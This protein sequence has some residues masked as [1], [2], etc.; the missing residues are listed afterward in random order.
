[1]LNLIKK[2]WSKSKA[3]GTANVLEKEAVH[4]V[5]LQNIDIRSNVNKLV[6]FY[7]LTLGEDSVGDFSTYIPPSV[8][9]VTN[10][11]FLSINERGAVMALQDTEEEYSDLPVGLL[12]TYPDTILKNTYFMLHIN[13][14]TLHKYNISTNDINRALVFIDSSNLLSFGLNLLY[15]PNDRV[16][17]IDISSDNF[18]AVFL[19]DEGGMVN[20]D[21][22]V[23]D[24][25][26][27][28]RNIL[29]VR[30]LLMYMGNLFFIPSAAHETLI[31]YKLMLP[32]LKSPNI[33]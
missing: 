15:H 26:S 17:T 27:G 32:L 19:L 31:H 25:E 29:E 4:N 13:Q 12:I 20:I 22:L 23:L 2:W 3:K 30:T 21:F 11:V 33:L 16:T 6:K 18:F 8:I 5:S 14:D 7:Y 10:R 9:S 28:K 1:M 24:E